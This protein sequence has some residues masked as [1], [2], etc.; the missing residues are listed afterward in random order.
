MAMVK[1]LFVQTD[2]GEN[3]IVTVALITSCFGKFLK[4]AFKNFQHLS[5]FSTIPTSWIDFFGRKNNIM[6]KRCAYE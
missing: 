5:S 3:R 2:V 1:R 4:I 6:E